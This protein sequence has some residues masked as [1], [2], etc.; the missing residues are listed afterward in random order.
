MT[1]VKHT[2]LAGYPNI[3]TVEVTL[4][5]ERSLRGLSGATYT[6]R[7]VYFGLRS[8]EGKQGYSVGQ[9]LFLFLPSPSQ[10]GLSSPIGI[11]QGR[12]HI[13]G[14]SA[15]GARLANEH[16]NSG[17]F[18]DVERDAVRA[19]K[20]LTPNQRK[21]AS[22]QTRSGGPGRICFAGQ[23]TNNIA[24][25]TMNRNKSVCFC[26]PVA[27]DGNDNPAGTA[28]GP[29]Y[30]TGPSADQPG[31]AYRW[32]LNPIPY[33]TDRG[34]LGNQ[35]NTQANTLVAES[36]NVWHSASTADISFSSSGQ[37]SSGFTSSNI[38]TFQNAIGACSDTSQPTNAIIYD[39]NGSIMTALGYDNNSTLGFS[40]AICADDTAGTFT[41]GWTV[42]NGRFIDG[43]PIL[44]R[45]VP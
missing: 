29:L 24:E 18:R 28:G 39:V 5:V 13:A 22:D 34:G 7:E 42:L 21:L 30:V 32:A 35:S 36:F 9:S 11:G 45:T 33:Q 16:G 37:L 10:Y 31:Q 43:T 20:Q 25:N 41:R 17:L 19:G 14:D 1:S 38:L 15:G 3:P 40:D 6:F 4:N 27:R 2:H 26:N 12:F 44:P 23:D 8:R